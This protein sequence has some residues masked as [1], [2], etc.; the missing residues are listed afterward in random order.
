MF[1]ERKVIIQSIVI[2]VALILLTRLFHLQIIDETSRL[3]ADN[4]SRRKY[5]EY[6]YRGLI[7][8]RNGEIIVY[9]KP[10]FDIMVVPSEV[11][12]EDTTHF[13]S[14][15][16]ITKEEYIERITKAKKY[17]YVKPS[18]FYSQMS[19]EEFAKIQDRFSE[20]SG[21]FVTPKTN[22]YYPF[23]GM[24]NALGYIGEV[25]PRIL[26]RDT[27]N[28]YK[29]GDLIGISGLESR[30][31][32]DLRGKRGVSFKMVNVHGVVKGQY[33]EGKADTIPE[34]GKNITTT[35]DIE[36]QKYG[37]KLMAGKIGSVVAIEPATGEILSII[38]APS[39]DPNLLSGRK[40]SQNYSKINTDSTK[41][42]Y[43]RPI[44]A[45]QYPPGSIFKMV[46]ALIA[47]EEGVITP[48]TR[49]V[50]NR[51]IIKCHGPHSYEDLKGAIKH[52]CNPYFY[53][54]FKRVIQQ[55]EAKSFNEDAAIGL[56]NW[57]AHL[58][59]FGLGQRLGID[60]PNER[61]GVVPTVGLY[62][63]VYGER[64]W[65]FFTVYSLSIG[66]GELGVSPL[67]M[68]NLSA[69]IAN[70]GYYITPHLVKEIDGS[71]DLVPEQY[72][73]KNYTSVTSD[74]YE[75]VVD[76]MDAVVN[77]GWS[78]TGARAHIDDI[79]VCGKTGT[80]QNPH[81]ED[82]SVFIAFAPKDNPKIAVSVYVE[83]AGQGARAAA[84]IAGL[85]IEKYLK[86]EIERKAIEEYVL[87]GDFIY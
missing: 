10:V 36:L 15:L 24:S 78:G 14:L 21:F 1:K 76:A 33:K 56:D 38:S 82:H 64:A 22:R 57:I 45:D 48:N 69:I 41:P 6:P 52:S 30:Y 72:R 62:N 85:M 50:C 61:T 59:T 42:L 5:I 58:K 55:G 28:Y 68:A 20:Y 51:S 3:A 67:Q 2:F 46:Q 71:K 49:F 43:N 29:S 63:R 18:V 54:S 75:V 17:S 34:P 19:N 35:V 60:L 84:S 86:R 81:G 65:N 7:Y 87:K 47:L 25:T 27:T 37:E 74:K 40:F 12:I 8:D 11:E 70:R 39:Y 32:E 9:N 83:N 66:Q 73:K 31:E 44:Q 53:E 4:N 13:C 77:S 23:S 16:D 80:A 26:N 79:V